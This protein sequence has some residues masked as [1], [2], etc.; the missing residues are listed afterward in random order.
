MDRK[1]IAPGDVLTQIMTTVFRVNSLLLDKG[2]QLVAPL[3]MTSA[4]WQVMGAIALSG[5]ALSCP[6]IA[7]AMGLTRQGAQKQLN[8][9]QRDG[10][11]AAQENPR[12]E[13]SP[14]YELTDAGRCSYNAAIASEEVWA[15]SLAKTMTQPDLEIALNVLE[16]LAARLQS[17]P[18]PVA[19]SNP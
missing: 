1:P 2:D 18:L 7:A 15:K 11:I 4:R 6:Q 3:G 12:H 9:A 17:T 10:L 16:T 19:S 8:Q 14:L 13:R 5:R